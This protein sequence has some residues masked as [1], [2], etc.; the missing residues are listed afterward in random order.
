MSIIHANKIPNRNKFRITLLDELCI[1]TQED[2]DKLW[3]DP[4][5]PMLTTGKDGHKG[6]TDDS[7]INFT[8]TAVGKSALVK[9]VYPGPNW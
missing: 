3:N 4:N 9:C 7:V 2:I 5:N 6:Q 1:S 8:E